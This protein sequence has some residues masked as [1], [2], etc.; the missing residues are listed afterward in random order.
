MPLTRTD[1]DALRSFWH[2]VSWATDLGSEPQATTL[3]GER[4]VLWRDSSGTPRCFA[5]LCAHRGTALSLGSVDGGCLVCPYH[6][7]A[8]DSSGACVAIPQLPAGAPI[9]PRVRATAYRCEEANG[10]IW[11]AL[12][13][14]AAPVPTFPEWGDPRYR[15]VM[16]KPYTWATS[17][18]RMVEN[19][20][21]FGHLGW[22]HDGLLGTRDS[23]VVP[24]HRA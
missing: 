6:G 5:D 20:T 17:A 15:H 3:L 7:W 18:P 12:D 16:C 23:L 8:F 10:L 1:P 13:E 9:P 24:R 19:F 14:P 22:L 2:P 21:D 11:V 4:L